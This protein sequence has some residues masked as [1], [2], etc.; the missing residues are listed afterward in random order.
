M[1][2]SL[3]TAP[4]RIHAG[5]LHT[6]IFNRALGAFRPKEVDSEL[7]DITYV[8]N[9][10]HILWHTTRLLDTVQFHLMHRMLNESLRDGDKLQ[11]QCGDPYVEKAVEDKI[12]QF[13]AWVEK[14]SRKKGQV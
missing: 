12:D 5:V 1:H 6:I 7:F 2:A 10:V 11:A 8:R 9:S 13:Y 4:S 3:T 14:H